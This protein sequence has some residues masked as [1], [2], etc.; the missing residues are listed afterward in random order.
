MDIVSNFPFEL[1]LIHRFPKYKEDIGNKFSKDEHDI[2]NENFCTFSA[3]ENDEI[4]ILF[5]SSDK[6]ARLYLDALDIM[7]LDD[8]TIS[9]DELGRLYR[10]VSSD[11]FVLYSNDFSYDALRVDSFKISVFC[12]G[13][14]YY[15]VFDIVPKPVSKN[16]WIMMRD[17]L[18]KE[19][20]GLAQDIVRRNIGIGDYGDA[21]IPPKI[22][23]DF[24]VIKKYSEQVM[25]ALVDIAENPKC[26]IRTEYENVLSYNSYKYRFDAE[27]MRR[28]EMR[29][30]S[31][32]TLR[33]PVKRTCYDIQD[34][35]LLK[36]ILE[37]YDGKLVQFIKLIDEA[38]AFSNT[39]H[40][41]GSIQYRNSWNQSLKDF[42]TTAN[43]LK[44]M[45][46]ILKSQA[47]YADV[48]NIV[49]PYIPHSFILDTRYNTLY[50]MHMELKKEMMHIQLNPEFS[51]TWKRS[52]YLYE[53]WCF[54]K[55]CHFCFDEYE[56]NTAD[57]NFTFSNKILF[58]FLE[59][60]TTV[61]FASNSIRIKLVYDKCLSL[62]NRK[63]GLDNPLYIA[64][65]YGS[66]R[67]HNRP[68]ILINVYEK[69][70]NIYLG[71]IV[72]EC[73]YRKLN[74][75]WNE[76]STRSSRGQLEAYYN[77]ARSTVLLAG[78]GKELNA[79]P[80]TKVFAL[81]PD[82]LAEGYEQEDFNIIIKTFKATDNNHKDNLLKEA[83]I[84]EIKELE[85]RYEKLK[86]A[87]KI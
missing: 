49:E 84:K 25:L 4:E 8:A 24:F 83:I 3:E 35:R 65:N 77:N 74:S 62:D 40:F 57:W 75:F 28:Y 10:M 18:E 46:A 33:I 12:Q 15:G 51:Y 2:W 73:K 80:V 11:S 70:K 7:P 61:E 17:D 45:T 37:E 38:E 86:N 60:G 19:I 78:L 6:Q 52:S 31:E 27:T 55:I 64:K 56:L 42:K 68:D 63:T 13:E 43:K 14:W 29:S 66:C 53:M 34:N 36:V 76:N 79:R 69:K 23:Y 9:E 26:Q 59:E 71:S 48:N 85:N 16:E 54:L 87:I 67:N 5:N 47:W 41:S 58:P 44:K 21:K 81:S 72:L 22:I 39:S 32:S 50:Q 30:G 82:D 1:K 20:Q